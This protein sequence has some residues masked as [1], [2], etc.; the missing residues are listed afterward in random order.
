MQ[1]SDQGAVVKILAK[2]RFGTIDPIIK[3][4]TVA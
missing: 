1:F 2:T 4:V 3:K